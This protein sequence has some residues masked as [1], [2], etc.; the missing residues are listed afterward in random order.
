MRFYNP[1]TQISQMIPYTN[2]TKNPRDGSTISNH[3]FIAPEKDFVEVPDVI[4]LMTP[5]GEATI[6]VGFG[7]H[8]KRVFAERGLV[9]VNPKAVNILDDD[10][11]ATNDKEARMKGDQMWKEYL[12]D[13][14]TEW[15]SIVADIKAQG[16]APRK[17]T[18]LFAFAL[19]SLH[20]EDPADTVD[21]ILRVK[22]DKVSNDDTQRQI[23]E[24]KAQ[25][26]QLIG[27]QGAGRLPE[28]TD[29]LNAR[30]EAAK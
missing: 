28:R 26:Q 8:L 20:M 13:K 7:R 25:V 5:E 9:H 16:G 17:A 24:L 21:T 12:K 6:P 2:T 18:G 14:V 11:T 10:N 29:E 4:T 30:R 1:G 23:E 22:E 19:R 27:A 3:L 15:Y